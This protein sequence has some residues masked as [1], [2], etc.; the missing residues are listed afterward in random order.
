MD[1]AILYVR[2]IKGESIQTQLDVCRVYAVAQGWEP[3][4]AVIDLLMPGPA[5]RLGLRGA[6]EMVG[7]GRVPVLIA[8]SAEHLSKDPV[9]LDAL[10]ETLQ[11]K[12]CVIRFVNATET[13]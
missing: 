7:A 8:Q 12:N 9:R 10:H 13:N 5:Y 1:T 4:A 6:M 2:E 3:V 11:E